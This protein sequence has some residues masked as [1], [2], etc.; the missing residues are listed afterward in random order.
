MVWNMQGLWVL[1]TGLPVYARNRFP[2]DRALNSVDYVGFSVFVVGFLIE[3]IADYQKFVFKQRKDSR[4]KFIQSGL[5]KLSRHPNYFGEILVWIGLSIASL[6][7]EI[8]HFKF[9]IQLLVLISPAFVTLLLTKV[10]GIPLLEAQADKKWGNDLKYQ[11]YKKNTPVL[12]P[13]NL[14]FIK[15]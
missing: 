13:K 6:S 12:V 2:G 10:S 5:W 9:S 4:E 11:E 3:C 1:L 15:F 8:M 7:S 14:N